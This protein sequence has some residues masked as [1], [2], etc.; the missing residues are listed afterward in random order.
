MRDS[1]VS[2]YLCVCVR[3]TGVGGGGTGKGEIREEKLLLIMLPYSILFDPII[4]VHVD[5]NI[6]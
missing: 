6:Y 4:E 2:I 3:D 5:T 1:Y